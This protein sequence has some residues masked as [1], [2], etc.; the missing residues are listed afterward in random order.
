MPE[1]LYVDSARMRQVLLNLMS[2]AIQFTPNRPDC[3]ARVVLSAA[4]GPLPLSDG[5]GG[6]L[7]RVTD[8]GIGMSEDVVARLFQ[9]FTQ[10]DSSTSRQFNGTGLGLSISQRLV[11][12]MGGHVTVQSTMGQGSELTVAIPLHEVAPGIVQAEKL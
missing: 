12:L 9:P 8:N 7:L 1:W 3:G 11:L 5:Q 10:A 6:L 4:R 2:N